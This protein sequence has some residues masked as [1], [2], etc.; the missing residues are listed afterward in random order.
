MAPAVGKAAFTVGIT[1][2]I[3]GLSVLFCVEPGSPEFVADVLSLV[4]VTAFLGLLIWNVR[5][6]VRLPAS[7]E[8]EHR[9]LTPSGRARGDQ[10]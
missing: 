6:A 10:N 1:V 5:R 8:M 7:R 4:F 3:M 2:L 9:G